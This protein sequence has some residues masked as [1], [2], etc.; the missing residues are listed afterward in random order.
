LR[1]FDYTVKRYPIQES[2]RFLA[3]LFNLVS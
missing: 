3:H 2:F 1:I